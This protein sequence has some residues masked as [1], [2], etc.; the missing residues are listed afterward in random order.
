MVSRKALKQE[1]LEVLWYST[2][3]DSVKSVFA[4]VG[5]DAEDK[6]APESWTS[7]QQDA[8]NYLYIAVSMM[9]SNKKADDMGSRSQRRK[10]VSLLWDALSNI[11]STEKMK[12]FVQTAVK[13]S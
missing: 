4:L 2:K 6:E 3:D 1:L 11:S 7:N 9:N 8:A 10:L 5:K 12:Q 13:Y